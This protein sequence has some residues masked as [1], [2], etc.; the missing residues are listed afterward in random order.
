MKKNYP[1][2][3]KFA[4]EIALYMESEPLIGSAVSALVLQGKK[5][6]AAV[7][8]W[9]S[10]ETAV[11]AGNVQS[12]LDAARTKEVQ[13]EAAD[14]VRKEAV[15]KARKDAGIPGTSAGGVHERPSAPDQSEIEA[16]AAAMRAMGSTPGNPAAARWR[17][18]TIGRTLPP[19]IFG[20]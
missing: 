12:T 20:S 10:Y 8:A 16:A 18:L 15:D 17:E 3:L 6:E 14:Q 2:A 5:Q 7:L 4:D 9:R 19:E 1:D 11:K 13:L